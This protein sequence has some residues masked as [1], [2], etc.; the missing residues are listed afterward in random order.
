LRARALFLRRILRVHAT[1]RYVGGGRS[2][3]IIK[4]S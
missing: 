3:K 2:L 1:E 4:A